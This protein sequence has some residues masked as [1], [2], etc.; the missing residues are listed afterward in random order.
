MSETNV[1][2]IKLKQKEFSARRKKGQFFLMYFSSKNRLIAP[3]IIIYLSSDC[4]VIHSFL[5][6]LSSQ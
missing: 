6:V 4:K 5:H 2:K 1:L 3:K